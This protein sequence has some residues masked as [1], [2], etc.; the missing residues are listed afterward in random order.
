MMARV[1]SLR[2]SALCLLPFALTCVFSTACGYALA[3]RGAHLPDYIKVIGVPTFVNKSAVADLDRTLAD[4]VRIELSGRKYRVES[5]ETGDAI[6][7]VTINS[8]AQIPVAFDASRQASRIRVTVAVNVDFVDMH[9]NKSLWSNPSMSYQE[10]YDVTTG[11]SVGDPN[12]F[13]GQNATALQRLAEN[14]A[15][16]VV[17]GMLETF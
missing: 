10:E 3:G 1:S 6:L 17:T 13:F 4:Q 14:F 5:S 15:K 11:T 9:T 7:H 2:T 8:V 16:A 12:A